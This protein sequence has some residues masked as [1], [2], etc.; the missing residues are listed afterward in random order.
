MRRLAQVFGAGAGA[1]ALAVAVLTSAGAATALPDTA[2]PAPHPI[3]VPTGPQSTAA[4]CPNPPELSS[5]L[6]EGAS[7]SAPSLLPQGVATIT[8]G[9][10]TF[11]L[12]NTC[13]YTLSIQAPNSESTTLSAGGVSPN[14]IYITYVG[15]DQDFYFPTGAADPITF[16]YNGHSCNTSAEIV[17]AFGLAVAEQEMNSGNCTSSANDPGIAWGFADAINTS[18]QVASLTQ[19][20]TFHTWYES[21]EAGTIFFGQFQE[22][23][24][25]PV[26]QQSTYVCAYDNYGPLF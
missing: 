22:C 11:D 17:S 25:N 1:A 10:S 9:G 6:P 5:P 13:E 26:G 15:S 16:S 8:V 7:I 19:E 3:L 20:P 23:M 12:G 18:E 21:Y 2:P 4:T 14:T 24:E